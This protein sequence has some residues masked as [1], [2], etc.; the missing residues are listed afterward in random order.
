MMLLMLH[1]HGMPV[2]CFF[3]LS[4]EPDHWYLHELTLLW[5]RWSARSL[6][7]E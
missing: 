1:V 7:G 2:A 5:Y 4:E 3:R 6:P